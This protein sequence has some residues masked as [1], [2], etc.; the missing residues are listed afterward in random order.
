MKLGG[1]FQQLGTQL[2]V[3]YMI[4]S[5]VVLSAASY[6]IYSFML[7]I[8]K[9]NNETLLLQQFH[10]TEHNIEGLIEDVDSLSKFFLLEPSAQRFL[11]YT[12]ENGN[13][14]LLEIKKEL[15]AEIQEYV[16]SYN[17]ID[18]IYMVGDVQGV[19]GGSDRTTL[20]HPN[21][22]WKERF[23]QSDIYLGSDDTFPSMKIKG[24]IKKA[25]YNPYMVH[26]YGGNIISMARAIRPLYVPITKGTLIMNVDETYL[27]SIYSASLQASDGKMYIVDEGGVVISSSLAS[28]VGSRSPYYPLAPGG[29]EYGSYEDENSSDS[30]QIVYYRLNEAGWYMVKEIPLGQFSDQ[31]YSMQTLLVA[32]ILASLIVI[33]ILSY[34]WLR[35]MIHPLRVLALKMKDMSRG[36]LGITFTKVPNNEFGMLIRRFNEMSLSIVDLIRETNEMQEKRRELELEALQNQINPHF[37][38]NTLNMIRWMA[39]TVKADSIV[40]SIIAL[41]NI[42]RPVFSSKEAMCTLRDELYYLENYIKIINMRFDNRI[43]FEIDVDESDLERKV[44]RF[45]LQPLIENSIAYG[46]QGE[47]LA[48][49]I[50]ICAYETDDHFMITVYDSGVGIDSAMLDQLNDRLQSGERHAPLSGAS[51]SGIGLYNVNKRIQ[52]NYGAGYGV[53]LIPQSEGTMVQ[54]GL[55]GGRE[56]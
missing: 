22:E 48:V 13:M 37:L 44:P 4:I 20:V 56:D 42:L 45:I 51:G 23:F 6:F 54:V 36:E 24:G 29:E 41:G 49:H 5:L 53:R 19:I 47:V 14:E 27:S 26:P 52:L 2:T 30:V 34:F 25:F 15:H 50:R 7:G 17:Y 40:N 32:V 31:I 12:P 55:P 18:S 1:R 10:Q 3:F 8:I 38:Y 33:F 35:K 21:G 43:V 46:R 28:D 9:E 11:N 39:S 16:S